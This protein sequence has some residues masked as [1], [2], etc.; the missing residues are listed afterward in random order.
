MSPREAGLQ[1][2]VNLLRSYVDKW[3]LAVNLFK[4]VAVRHS[5]SVEKR[6]QR[7]ITA[8]SSSDFGVCQNAQ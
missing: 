5:A 6:R 4:K 7:G 8:G 2:Q 3:D 1:H